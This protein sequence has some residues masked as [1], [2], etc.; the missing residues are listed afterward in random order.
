M[1]TVHS[2][3]STGVGSAAAGTAGIVGFVQDSPIWLA[4]TCLIL[5]LHILNMG[6]LEYQDRRLRRDGRLDG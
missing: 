1:S 5:G 4:L 6:R 3:P 2:L